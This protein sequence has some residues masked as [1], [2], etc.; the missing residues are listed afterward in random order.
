M[1]VSL[2]SYT[3]LHFKRKQLLRWNVCQLSEDRNR[4]NIPS[5]TKGKRHTQRD[6]LWVSTSTKGF[7]FF[8]FLPFKFLSQ[9]YLH[10]CQTAKEMPVWID[11]ASPTVKTKLGQGYM[12]LSKTDGV[13]WN[14]KTYLQKWEHCSYALQI[15]WISTLG[16]NVIAIWYQINTR[17]WSA[18]YM[19]VTNGL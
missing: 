17:H 3:L 16:G 7:F 18:A 14:H 19:Y 10:N 4:R 2:Q 15:Q 6:F 8:N 1:L 13:T 9:K 12:L 11:V 5:V